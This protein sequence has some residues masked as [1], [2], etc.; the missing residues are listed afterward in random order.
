MAALRGQKP[1][2][3]HDGRHGILQAMV[4]NEVTLFHDIPLFRFHP[5]KGNV[6]DFRDLST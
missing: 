6:T 5:T 3:R 4:F 2:L 1:R